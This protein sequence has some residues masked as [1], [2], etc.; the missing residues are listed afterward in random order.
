MCTVVNTG[1]QA[2]KKSL[3]LCTSCVAIF[4]FSDETVVP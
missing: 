3:F 4:D 2:G 1:R